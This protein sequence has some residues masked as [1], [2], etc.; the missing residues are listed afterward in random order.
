MPLCGNERRMKMVERGMPA[1]PDR[2]VSRDEDETEMYFAADASRI[3]LSVTAVCT[4]DIKGIIKRTY[5][6]QFSPPP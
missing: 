5:I 1:L 2:Q 6:K 4:N 3:S